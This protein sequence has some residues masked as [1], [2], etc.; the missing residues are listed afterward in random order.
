MTDTSNGKGRPV[1]NSDTTCGRNWKYGVEVTRVGSHQSIEKSSASR[2]GDVP[3]CSDL[4]FEMNVQK[5]F[6][7][8]FGF[9]VLS[10]FSIHSFIAE[11]NFETVVDNPSP[12]I[13]VVEQVCVPGIRF[14]STIFTS[15][16]LHDASLA[17]MSARLY[18]ALIV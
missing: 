2:D 14:S 1:R 4:L 16:P 18:F 11:R 15:L 3:P 10:L 8:R 12:Q 5:S 13:H 17:P 6:G 7:A 9:E